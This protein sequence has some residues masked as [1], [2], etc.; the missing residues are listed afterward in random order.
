MVR[1]IALNKRYF[2]TI[3]RKYLLM[4]RGEEKSMTDIVKVAKKEIAELERMLKKIDTFLIDAPDGYLK[5][6]NKAGRTYY[7]H[8]YKI[9]GENG[10]TMNNKEVADTSKWKREYIKKSSPLAETLAQKQ[11]YISI[12]PILEKNLCELKRFIN[13]YKKEN[14]DNIYELLSDERKKL[15]TPLKVSVN[16]QIK[17]WQEETYEKNNMYSENLRYETEQGDLVRSKSEVIIANILYQHRK[18]IL[19]KYE[20]PL[21]L[22]IEGKMKTVYPD[23]TIINVHTGKITYW[24]HAGRMDDSHYAGEFVKKINGYIGNGLVIGKDVIVSFET[25]GSPLD[26]GIVKR[27]VEAVIER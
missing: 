2:L 22:M 24:E 6:Q 3:Y 17:R 9:D 12:K 8:Q 7:Y 25:Q 27:L 26:I 10:G 14:A 13:K 19:Y 23:F 1:S 4:G 11:Y 15:V 16:E 18:D 5:W 21:T 20:R